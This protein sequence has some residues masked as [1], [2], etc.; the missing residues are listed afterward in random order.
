MQAELAFARIAHRRIFTVRLSP[1][2]LA[3]FIVRARFVRHDLGRAHAVEIAEIRSPGAV[4]TGFQAIATADTNIVVDDDGA[5]FPLPGGLYRANRNARRIVA[6]HARLRGKYP[7]HIGIF[8]HLLPEDRAVDNSRR[9]IVFGVAGQVAGTASNT[10]L[11][12]DDH[13]PLA[14]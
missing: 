10:F 4:W 5:V 11:L 7:S 12:V 13:N 9:E 2:L 3:V 14:F 8:P 6:M 1:P